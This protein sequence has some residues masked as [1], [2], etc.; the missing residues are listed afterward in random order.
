MVRRMMTRL[1]HGDAQ[2]K[3]DARARTVLATSIRERAVTTPAATVVRPAR[4]WVVLVA[5]LA[6]ALAAGA[7]GG[8]KKSGGDTYAKASDVQGDCCEHLSGDARSQCVSQIVHVDDQ[9]VAKTSVNQQTY[10]CVTQHFQCDAATGH[11]TLASAQAQLECIQD[12]GQ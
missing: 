1:V 3:P 9:N 8:G 6:A 5:C 4:T 7:C 2:L 10:A 12:L 11:A